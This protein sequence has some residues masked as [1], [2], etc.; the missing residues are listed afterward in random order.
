MD[1]VQAC[2]ILS[3]AA[4]REPV[5]AAL[6]ARARAHAVVCPE[7]AAFARTLDRLAES[8]APLPSEEFVARLTEL[9]AVAAAE[10]R[11]ASLAQSEEPAVPAPPPPTSTRA[12]WVP[13][14]AAFAAAAVILLVALGAGSIALIGSLGQRSTE[15]AAPVAETDTTASV[16]EDSGGESLED[17]GAPPATVAPAPDYV[18]LDAAVWVLAAQQ[19]PPS[20]QL[21]TVGVVTSTLDDGI[22]GTHPAYM[23]S[24]DPSTMWVRKTNGTYLAFERV[25]RTLGRAPYGLVTGTAIAAFGDWPTLP[26]EFAPPTSADGSPTFRLF[27]FDDLNVDIYVEPTGNA[28]QGFAVA[29]GTAEDDPAAG[30][31]N[32]TW[33]EPLE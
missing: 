31:P 16:A 20:S 18:S 24:G 4:D 22:G 29:P 14:F 1:C 5:D 9:G 19:T 7:C 26:S 23:V 11:E 30:N 32:W 28:Q 2:E 10:I 8:P 15:S 25:V 27:G 21:T 17:A 12:N 13:R 3:A 6:L 33:W